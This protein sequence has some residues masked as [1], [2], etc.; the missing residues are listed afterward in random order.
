[1][2]SYI[3]TAHNIVVK[4]NGQTVLNVDNVLLKE[5]TTLTIIGEN[6]AGKTTLLLALASLIKPSGGEISFKNQKF[7]KDIRTKEYRKNIAIVFQENLLLNDTVFNNIAIGL[8]F[9]KTP[10]EVITTKVHEVMEMLNI[11]GLKDRNAVGLSGGEAKR[12]SIARAIV[13]EPAIL[14]LDEPFSSLDTVSKESIITDLGKIIKE[15]NITTV[16]TTHDRYEALRLADEIVVLEKGRIVQK[17][18]PAELFN[19]PKT[20]FVASFFGIENIIEGI[21]KEAKDGIIKV[22]TANN[23]I[24]AKGEASL[25]DE[26]ILCIRPENVFVTK[27]SDTHQ[28]SVRNMFEGKIEDIESYGPFFR[29]TINCGFKIVSYITKNSLMELSLKVGDK[30]FAGFKAMSVHSLKR[31]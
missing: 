23:V 24:S 25:G 8:K 28:T 4:R 5:K 19:N 14:F 22:A 26:V 11:S 10:V 15:K 2:N 3:L 1:M 18:S 27:Y 6:G 7:G 12:V 30:A 13:I 16:I 9:R 31:G 20:L 17:G 21:V 29:I